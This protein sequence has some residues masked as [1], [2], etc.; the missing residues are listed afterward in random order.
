MDFINTNHGDLAT[1]LAQ[2]LRK[3][4]LRCNE[5]ALDLLVFDCLEHSLLRGKTLLRVN[6]SSWNEIRQFTKLVSHQ[7]NKWSDN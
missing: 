2:I 3:E 4:S 6:T 1:I 7:C 5:K